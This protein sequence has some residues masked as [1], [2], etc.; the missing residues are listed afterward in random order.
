MQPKDHFP[1]T[2]NLACALLFNPRSVNN[3][4][5]LVK[6]LV[7]SQDSD[8]AFL[9]ES[10]LFPSQDFID[11][12]ATQVLPVST[13][14]DNHI[15]KS[16]IP[17]GYKL[18]HIPRVDRTGGGVAI[19]HKSSVKISPQPSSTTQTSFEYME[20]ISK[21]NSEHIRFVLVYRPPPSSEN[22]LTVPLFLNE[23]SILLE[24]LTITNHKTVILGDFNFHI[25]SNCPFA[26]RFLDL[27]DLYGFEQN[28]S[29]PT[30]G[31]GHTLD[32]VFTRQAEHNIVSNLSCHD[33]KLSDHKAV[34]FNLLTNKPPFQR[35]EI[36]Y[37]KW[38]EF[39][40]DEFHREVVIPSH[41]SDMFVNSESCVNEHPIPV[42]S[43]GSA[44]YQ[45]FDHCLSVRSNIVDECV[46][47]YNDILGSLLEKHAP[48]QQKTVTLRPKADWYNSSIDTEK[49]QKRRL[50]HKWLKT[51]SPFDESA[52]NEQCKK[53]DA[54][55]NDSKSTYYNNKISEA[56]NDQKKLFGLI[57]KI[58]HKSSDKKLPS[59]DDTL[60][61]CTQ[62]SDFFITKIDKIRES[63]S[64]TS[65]SDTFCED[66][67]FTG[68]FMLNFKRVTENDIRI[69]LIN[70]PNKHCHLDPIPT[71]ILKKCADSLIPLITLIVNLSLD[72]G[73]MPR[74]LKK[75]LLT[76][77][78]KKITDDPEVLNSFRPISN[79]PFLSKIIEKVV[80]DQLVSHMIANDLNE[81]FQ[82]SYK[83]LH[84]TETA[85]NC[86]INDILLGIDNKLRALLLVLDM[87]AGFDTVDHNIL[88]KRLHNTIGLRGFVFNWFKSYLSDREQAVSIDGIESESRP[89]K[90]GVPQG[91]VL[92]PILFNIYIMPLAN[93]IKRHEIP[94]HLYA[95]DSQKYAIFDLKDYAAT[96]SK[97]DAL[98]QDIRVWFHANRL[99]GNDS[100]TEAMLISSKFAPV[101]KD[102]LIPI[103]VGN[104]LINQSSSIKNLGVTLDQHA[105]LEL[106]I[107]NVARSAFLKIREISYYRRHLTMDAAKTLMHAFVTSRIDYCNS[108]FYGL[109]NNLI[110]KLQSVLNT[111]ARVVTKTRKHDSITPV[112]YHLHW[113]P[114]KFRIQ[115]KLLLLVFKALNG[116]APA[117]LLDK[118]TLKPQSKLRSSNQKLLI[119]PQSNMKNY[120]D[121]SFS[122]AGPK[123]WNSLP[124]TLRLTSSVEI[125]KK[126][127]K[128]HLFKNAFP[129][130]V[131]D[132]YLLD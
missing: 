32:L 124:K 11:K 52:Y 120:G 110:R 128:T 20:V 131:I 75:A 78:I 26:K 6:D 98:A 63:F 102:Q 80:A 23:F 54:L 57:N 53:V 76:P 72:A 28:V 97:L 55:I 116:S 65:D 41:I 74:E 119:V 94:F 1:L 77:L 61:L 12:Y 117:Y 59:H 40:F 112:L 107:K 25:E 16:L 95:D 35:K 81:I 60:D 31:H 3:K 13:G 21:F 109:P 126:N 118:L 100:K 66:K 83:K 103:T 82:S 106:H 18:L 15:I 8:I 108:L 34:M 50:E 64:H 69:I 17:R 84:S 51:K 9:V 71:N 47:C 113:L 101:H 19:L 99:K 4:V 37:R 39:D 27:L 30:H 111:A 115:F 79:L 132:R 92:G 86:V 62:F 127:L 45:S 73:H 96:V 104:S 105:T 56:G 87:S 7:V 38:K 10:W 44:N 68:A 49:R 29:F 58:F 70:A 130:S 24:E 129:A 114:V 33:P 121:R 67:P 122:V 14:R 22:G 88:L 42:I 5:D 123:L 46:S 89:L 36:S 43:S 90:Y 85:L 48:M 91:S 125:F 93:L 2:R